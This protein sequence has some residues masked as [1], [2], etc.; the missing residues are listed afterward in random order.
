MEFIKAQDLKTVAN[1]MNALQKDIINSAMCGLTET[2]D[3]HSLT[4]DSKLI[5]AIEKY[6]TDAGYK[7][8]LKQA[9][10]INGVAY[11]VIKVNWSE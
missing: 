9:T 3:K 11:T 4:V 8:Y 2:R 10:S 1:I 6:L 5:N 7:V